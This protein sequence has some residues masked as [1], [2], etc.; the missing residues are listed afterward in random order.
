MKHIQHHNSTNKLRIAILI[1]ESSLHKADIEKHYVEPLKSLGLDESSIITFSLKYDK[2]TAS[3]TKE[4]LSNLL[5]ALQSLNIDILLVTDSQYFK[6]LT[7]VKKT[8]PHLGYIVP[9]KIKGY[10][11]MNCILSMNYKALFYNPQYQTKIDLSLSTLT[12]HI[13]G[14]YKE[15][16]SDIIHSEAY[17]DTIEEIALWLDRL[18]QYDALT[19]DTETR[20]LEFHNAGLETIA[21]AW[22]EHNFVSFCVDKD[23]TSCKALR[24]KQKLKEFFYEYK[25]KIVY[26]NAGYDLKILTYQ[27]FMNNLL[28]QQGLLYGLEVMTK[29]I[30]DAKLVTYL[31][32]NSCAGNTLD[33]KSNSHQFAGNYALN[34]T[35]TTIIS[36]NELLRYGG[37]DVLATW[38]VYKK[39][40]PIMVADNQLDT[41]N[42]IFIPSVKVILQM[43]LQ[44]MTLDMSQVLKAEQ[45]LI[46]IKDIQLLQIQDNSLI[47]QLEETLT[48]KAWLKDFEDRKAKAKHPENIKLREIPKPVIFNPGSPKQLI[49]LVY[50]QFGLEITDYTDK[51]NPST[52]GKVLLKKFNHLLSEFN[53]AEDS[54]KMDESLQQLFE[55]ELHD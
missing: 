23:N 6:T 36:K 12:N 29:N 30:G 41:Y 25:G 14:F 37:I 8:D 21:F 13:L 4:Y 32:T 39:N 45:E 40:Y 16:G 49:E 47:K 2:P 18:Y 5:P 33:L 54:L 51:K 43:E 35:D 19:C 38:Y 53:L 42:T 20:S 1:K 10:E 34:I 26:F 55:E 22:N 48:N 31:A 9:C 52:G 11:Y 46:S 27:L 7:G 50:N 44:G 3:Q 24:I 17:P 15:I 28:D